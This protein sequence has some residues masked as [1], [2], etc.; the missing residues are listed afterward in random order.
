MNKINS[1]LAY[2]DNHGRPVVSTVYSLTE[3]EE[4]VARL[5]GAIQIETNL[6]AAEAGVHA[7][8][9]LP[10]PD[11]SFVEWLTCGMLT[12]NCEGALHSDDPSVMSWLA[13]VR[14]SGRAW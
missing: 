6:S 13:S 2:V 14:T 11:P 1:P 4:E 7:V 10:N 5:R 3:K 8:S 12:L 9:A